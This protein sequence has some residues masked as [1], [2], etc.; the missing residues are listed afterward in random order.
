MN[1]IS[2]VSYW[3]TVVYYIFILEL[4][5]HIQHGGICTD[6]D[7]CRSH[8]KT[9]LD[10]CTDT[11]SWATTIVAWYLKH[12]APYAMFNMTDISVNLNRK[13]IWYVRRC[14]VIRIGSWAVYRDTYRIVSHAYRPSPKIHISQ[15]YCRFSKRDVSKRLETFANVWPF[16]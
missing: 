14:I 7:F 12:I 9:A 13:A 1:I 8:I 2:F 4:C 10:T 3:N 16:F 11:C 6:V 5:P 15:S